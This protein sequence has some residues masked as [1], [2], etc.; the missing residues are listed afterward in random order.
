MRKYI[1]KQ[2]DQMIRTVF[3]NTHE[4]QFNPWKNYYAI[5]ETD[6]T[7]KVYNYTGKFRS[8]AKV[9]FEEQARIDHGKFKLMG[10]YK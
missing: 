7:D 1:N 4:A 8:E 9:Y 3:D 5:I 10:V 6:G 2:Q